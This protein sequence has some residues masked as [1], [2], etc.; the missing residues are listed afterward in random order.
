M[1][2]YGSLPFPRGH[3][4]GHA[5]HST[6]LIFV[7]LTVDSHGVVCALLHQ[8]G[9]YFQEGRINDSLFLR[10]APVWCFHEFFYKYGPCAFLLW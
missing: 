9:R 1:F 2:P 4:N 3:L 7:C 10:E 6:L 5:H 8:S